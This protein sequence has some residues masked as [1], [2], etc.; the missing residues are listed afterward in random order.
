[1]KHILLLILPSLLVVG[2]AL[3]QLPSDLIQNQSPHETLNLQG[4]SSSSA[5]AID[6]SHAEL[7]S[8]KAT[9]M[10]NLGH[11]TS[12]PD[13]TSNEGI[14]KSLLNFSNITESVLVSIGHGSGGKVV[15]INETSG[16]ANLV[17]L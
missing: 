9:N 17:Y 7:G 4:V 10:A 12:D 3:G 16:I 14:P 11:Y 6:S 1:M 2:L 13:L 15:V 5:Q 8:W